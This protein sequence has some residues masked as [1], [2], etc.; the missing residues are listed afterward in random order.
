[1]S[2]YGDVLKSKTSGRSII[3]VISNADPDAPAVRLRPCLMSSCDVCDWSADADWRCRA[4]VLVIGSS[5]AEA[6][7]MRFVG[8]AGSASSRLVF[9]PPIGMTPCW[10]SS[11]SRASSLAL[12]SVV[13]SAFLPG[14]WIAFKEQLTPCWGAWRRSGTARHTLCVRSWHTELMIRSYNVQ[15]SEVLTHQHGHTSTSV[16]DIL[17]VNP[18]TIITAVDS[19]TLL[20]CATQ[21][22]PLFSLA[23]R[24]PSRPL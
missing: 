20:T 12:S 7:W 5:A 19:I 15:H 23:S 1:M 11:S 13:S 18:V 3:I 2:S 22:L 16:C 21:R 17:L 10:P 24:E 9:K 14:Q 8:W 6:I 4:I